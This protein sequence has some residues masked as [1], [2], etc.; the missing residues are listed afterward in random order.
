MNL[1]SIYFFIRGGYKKKYNL[2]INVNIFKPTY[3]DLKVMI[4]A[5]KYAVMVRPL[6]GFA[7]GYDTRVCQERSSIGRLTATN[8]SKLEICTVVI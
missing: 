5:N 3:V 7:D 1:D 8:L 6:S 2:E 4:V